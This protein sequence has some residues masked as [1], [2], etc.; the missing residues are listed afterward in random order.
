MSSKSVHS[1]SDTLPPQILFLSP[2]GTLRQ[3]D[4]LFAKPCPCWAHS[5]FRTFPLITHHHVPPSLPIMLFFQTLTWLTHLLMSYLNLN[6]KQYTST[7]IIDRT[8]LVLFSIHLA[9]CNTQPYS[10]TFLFI[11]L[12]VF[13]W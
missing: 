6:C 13:P 3:P 8:F 5:H 12:S 2:S 9:L 1:F 10:F 7:H 11:L 4:G